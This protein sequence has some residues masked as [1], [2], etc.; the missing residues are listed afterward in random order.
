MSAADKR[1]QAEAILST[2]LLAQTKAFVAELR[3]DAPIDE[4][5]A[6]ELPPEGAED[7][8]PPV[9]DEPPAPSSE[10]PPP[11]EEDAG[12]WTVEEATEALRAMP[13][14]QLAIWQ[15]AMDAV[16]GGGMEGGGEPPADEPPMD[17]MKSELA[18]MEA[19]LEARFGAQIASLTKSQARPQRRAATSPAPVPQKPRDLS[20][21]EIRSRLD[22]KAKDP[23]LAKSDRDAIN[24]YVLGRTDATK[25][26]HLLKD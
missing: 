17:A 23:A 14:E 26:R 25:I 2:E 5:P 15:Q 22:V 4:E 20:K 10:T 12:S 3:K 11:A 21:A 9:G 7:D 24:N 18:K 8:A 6:D 19:R 1:A 16:A 13:P